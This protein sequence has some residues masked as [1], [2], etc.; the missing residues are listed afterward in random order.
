MEHTDQP[1]QSPRQTLKEKDIVCLGHLRHV[2]G[3]LD[4]LHEVGCE[5]DKAANRQLH[6]DDYCKLVLLYIW[7]PL[8]ESVHELQ[9]AVGLTNVAKVLGVKRFSASSFSESVRVFDPQQLQPILMELAGQLEPDAKDPRLNQLKT[10]L[11]LVDGTVLRGLARLAKAAVGAE[12]RYNTS[13]DGRGMYGWRLHTQFDLATFTPLGLFRTGARNA[14]DQRESNMLRAKLEPGRCYVADGGYADRS[15]FDDIVTAKSNYVIRGAEN[16][17]CT[18]LEERLLSQ[19]ALDAGVVRDAV[20]ELGGP[21]NHRVR[22]VEIQVEAHPRRGRGGYKQTDLIILYTD[23]IDLAVELIALIYRYRYTVELFFRF[24]KQLLGMR[25]L[26]SQ[27]EEGIDIQIYCTLIV[28]V[29]I[30]LISGKK[31]NKAMRNMVGWYLLGLASQQ[32]V[33]DFLNKPDNT[34]VKKRAKDA[35]WKKLGY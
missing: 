9:Q 33:I 29:L 22:P 12:A 27:R 23:L 15:L 34:G 11:T 20:V 3:L 21:T 18:V 6:F 28:C 14:A 16:S 31:P 25:H 35:L 10:A 8:I 30:Q 13:R 2:L 26:L 1:R 17:V 19:Q 7:N 4:R 32:E 5:R 24:F